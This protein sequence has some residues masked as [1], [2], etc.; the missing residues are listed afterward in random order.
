MVDGK[1]A[2]GE[3]RWLRFFRMKMERYWD[4]CY[5]DKNISQQQILSSNN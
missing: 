5:P 2:K 4:G 1:K 3:E